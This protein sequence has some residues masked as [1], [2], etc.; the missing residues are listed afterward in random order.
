[1]MDLL[2]RDLA[3]ITPEG[4]AEI[5][6]EARRVLKLNLGARK[7][8]DM[9]GPHG[10]GLAAVNLGRLDLLKTPKNGVHRGMRTVQRL[11][12]LR[13]PVVLDIMELDYA[14]RG[15]GD[16]DLDPLVRAAETIAHA[17]DQA[18]FEG[19]KELGITGIAGASSH[20]PMTLPKDPGRYPHI[21]ADAIRVLREAG[22]NGPFGLALGDRAFN[23]LASA[24]EDG[25]PV[26]KRV[27][28]I[29]EG[30]IV[31][32]PALQGGALLSVR[33]G[34]FALTVGQ[35]LSIGYAHRDRGQVELYLTESFTFRVLEPAAAVMLRHGK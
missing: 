17:E 7:L 35:D 31:R 6:E 3:P 2:K 23:D 32:S 26:R 5:D 34:D 16:P 11:A 10:W 33:G 9:D 1:M 22:I 21:M 18:I 29:L 27:L 15:A 13:I 28:P 14:A 24:A 20:K 8:V 19:D 25:Y 12:E 30:P 4:W